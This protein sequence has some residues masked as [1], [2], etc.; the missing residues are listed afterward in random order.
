MVNSMA[1]WDLVRHELLPPLLLS[2]LSG[3][4]GAEE[5][6][7]GRMWTWEATAVSTWLMSLAL[8]RAFE[9]LADRCRM[10]LTAAADEDSLSLTGVTG[11]GSGGQV[12]A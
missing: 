7:G 3:L 12:V 2:G 1:P 10:G 6:L 11:L 4:G 8:M 5:E 9:S